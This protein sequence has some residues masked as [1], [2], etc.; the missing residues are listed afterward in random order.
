MQD[1][2]FSQLDSLRQIKIIENGKV[3]VIKSINHTTVVPLF[4]SVC[5]LPM[6]TSDDSLAYKT[7][8]ACNLCSLHF[9]YSNRKKWD[10]ENWRPSK[11][12]LEEYL[13]HRELVEKPKLI[14]K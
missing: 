12:E 3:L 5:E 1:K 6:K 14:V 7:F 8:K 13:S 10:E 4:C 11:K 9:A 2:E